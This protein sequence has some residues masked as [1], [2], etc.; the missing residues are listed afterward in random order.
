MITL[1]NMKIGINSLIYIT[2]RVQVFLAIWDNLGHL[3]GGN[4]IKKLGCAPGTNLFARKPMTTKLNTITA[5]QIQMD[6]G[7]WDK[8]A[9]I[10]PN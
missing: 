3:K 10:T 1:I 2:R 4:S 9:I 7:R 8:S 6:F 5:S